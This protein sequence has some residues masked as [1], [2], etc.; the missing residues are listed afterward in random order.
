MSQARLDTIRQEV[1]AKHL[2]KE[3]IVVAGLAEDTACRQKR[4]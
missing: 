4:A 1:R 3:E 2:E